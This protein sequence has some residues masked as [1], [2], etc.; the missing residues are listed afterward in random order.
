MR[1]SSQGPQDM[2]TWTPPHLL[3]HTQISLG[4]SALPV[5]VHFLKGE[6]LH[7]SA[8]ERLSAGVE[9]DL[10]PV[11]R[12][13]YPYRRKILAKKLEECENSTS[14]SG[15]QAVGKVVFIY[16]DGSTGPDFERS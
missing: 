10:G 14:E 5:R 8:Q 3:G 1:Q 4:P 12:D 16:Q 6:A 15:F 11:A 9:R 7:Q 13:V 2:L